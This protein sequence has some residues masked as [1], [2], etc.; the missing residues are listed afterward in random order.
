MVATPTIAESHPAALSARPVASSVQLL[1][2]ADASPTE[3]HELAYGDWAGLFNAYGQILNAMGQI[4]T[5]LLNFN[6]TNML[7]FTA[8][9]PTLMIGP[10]AIGNGHLAN[11]YYF[12]YEGSPAGIAGV[13]AYL[14]G[15]L[16]TD[17]SLPALVKAVVLGLT[18]NIP[19]FYLGPVQ[20]GGGLLADAWFNGYGGATGFSGVVNYV[21]AQISPPAAAGAAKSATAETRSVAVTAREAAKP[22]TGHSARAA[23]SAAT[24]RSARAATARAAAASAHK[25]QE[26][27]ATSAP[28]K[29]STTHG[30]PKRPAA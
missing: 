13:G 24:P 23:Q 5:G 27:A 8:Q 11:A 18:S 20:V 14:F 22:A 16:Q 12:G 25:A 6:Q 3:A 21:T 2:H 28:A 30:G 29:A 26:S 19:K 10:V 4:A 7:A 15:T 9:I 1:A 17:L